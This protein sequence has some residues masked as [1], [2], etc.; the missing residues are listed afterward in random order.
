VV[1]KALK[2]APNQTVMANS[3][4]CSEKTFQ[5]YF[6]LIVDLLAIIVVIL[7]RIIIMYLLP[8]CL[9]QCTDTN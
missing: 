2:T 3:A 6:W 4:G 9:I 8:F 7:H 1:L 5:K